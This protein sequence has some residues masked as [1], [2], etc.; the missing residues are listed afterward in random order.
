M[1]FERLQQTDPEFA[2]RIDAFM[3]QEVVSEES[4]VLDH[5][6]RYMAIL[7]TL[8]GCQGSGMYREEVKSALPT[9]ARAGNRLRHAI[10]DPAF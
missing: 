3:N 2:Q 7:S 6:T 9:V 5:R 1:K 4:A 8:I 10:Y